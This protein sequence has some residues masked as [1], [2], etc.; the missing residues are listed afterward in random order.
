CEVPIDRVLAEGCKLSHKLVDLE[1][2]RQKRENHRRS[3]E[4][5]RNNLASLRGDLSRTE[6]EYGQARDRTAELDRQLQAV[7]KA[8]DTQADAWYRARRMVDEAARYE[9]LLEAHAS[10]SNSLDALN[11]R[12]EGKREQMSL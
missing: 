7:E 1:S 2:I 12:L 4:D 10:A 9:Q 11:K 3:L 5:E 6:R 8:R